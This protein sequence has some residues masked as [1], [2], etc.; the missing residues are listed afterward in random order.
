MLDTVTGNLAVISR[1]H[2]FQINERYDFFIFRNTFF[3]QN[4]RFL[5]HGDQKISWWRICRWRAVNL[6]IHLWSSGVTAFG[7]RP[8]SSMSKFSAS[9]NSDLWVWSYQ[10]TS[11]LR[12]VYLLDMHTCLVMVVSESSFG[13]YVSS[14]A[15]GASPQ[16]AILFLKHEEK[17]WVYKTVLGIFEVLFRFQDMALN[18]PFLQ[19]RA[20]FAGKGSKEI[21]R[22]PNFKNL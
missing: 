2:H 15:C 18:V 12:D 20:F 6:E 9:V 11:D 17:A 13:V 22:R 19:N 3:L 4:Y 5:Y 7:D 21:G 8:A 14:E 16:P 1:F 10:L